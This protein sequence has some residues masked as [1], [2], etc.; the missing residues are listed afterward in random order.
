[1][2]NKRDGRKDRLYLS[3]VGE[4]SEFCFFSQQLPTN[5]NNYPKIKGTYKNYFI[6]ILEFLLADCWLE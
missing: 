2:K 5:T 1:M 3:S 4:L 6:M